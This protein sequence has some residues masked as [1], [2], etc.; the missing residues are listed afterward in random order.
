MLSAVTVIKMFV[1]LCIF[2]RHTECYT[3]AVYHISP[4]SGH[5]PE[6]APTLLQIS[7]RRT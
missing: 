7:N 2:S 6:E 5:T 4:D 3:P 1:F